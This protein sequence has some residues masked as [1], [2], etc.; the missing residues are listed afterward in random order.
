MVGCK[1]D[2]SPLLRDLHA[3]H[4]RPVL[5]QVLHDDTQWFGRWLRRWPPVVRQMHL[6]NRN[7]RSLLQVDRNELRHS[8][9]QILRRLLYVLSVLPSVGQLD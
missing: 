1:V 4:R 5:P 8:C 6:P 9:D 2:H 7:R 3:F